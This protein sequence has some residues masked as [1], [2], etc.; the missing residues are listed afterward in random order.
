MIY[1]WAAER[2]N[3]FRVRHDERP[4][5]QGWVEF[6][7]PY[8]DQSKAAETFTFTRGRQVRLPVPVEDFELRASHQ[9]PAIQIADI[10]ASAT[11]QMLRSKALGVDPDAFAIELADA[12]LDRFIV[13]GVWPD[14]TIFGSPPVPGDHGAFD[15]MVEWLRDSDEGS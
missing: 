3:G 14:P 7:R 4:D 11:T 8:F 5:A 12:G 1:E 9:H 6:M 10:L 13:D 15:A 2:P